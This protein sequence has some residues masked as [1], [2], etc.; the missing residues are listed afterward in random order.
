MKLIHSDMS[1]AIL[2]SSLGEYIYYVSFIYD[3]S[4]KT[5][6]FLLKNKYEVF[7]EIERVK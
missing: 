1:G 3:F 7:L 5:W 6:L 4:R 2:V